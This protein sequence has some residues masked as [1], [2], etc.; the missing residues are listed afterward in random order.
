MK[1]TYNRFRKQRGA[2]LI[3]ALAFA[4]VIS[5]IV[6]GIATIT[7]SHY[8]RATTEGDYAAA[9]HMAEAGINWEIRKMSQTSISSDTAGSPGAGVV[10][11]TIAGVP[12]TV[13]GS[14]TAW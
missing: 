8:Q 11:Y 6:A 4:I 5:L 1:R 12:Y 9:L 13:P 7:V 10:T 3:T 14:Y 2:V